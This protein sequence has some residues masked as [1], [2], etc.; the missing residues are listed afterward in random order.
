MK[1]SQYV[2]SKKITEFEVASTTYDVA[3]KDGTKIAVLHLKTPIPN[4][5]GSSLLT[6]EVTNETIRNEQ[7]DVDTVRVAEANF[8][9]DG[10]DLNED[11]SGT[12]KCDLRLDVSRR[13]EVWLTKES[14]SSFGRKSSRNR[15]SEGRTSLMDRIKERQT[16]ATF[17]S[18]TTDAGAPAGNKPETVATKPEVKAE[19]PKPAT[20]GTK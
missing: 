14:F 13:G 3:E 10:I 17:A 5:K 18:N 6:D 12:V 11:G 9:V 19:G 15:R 2:A 4:V 16:R 7:W 20:V 1:L 8:D